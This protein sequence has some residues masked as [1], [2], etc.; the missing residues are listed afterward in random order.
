MGV[1]VDSGVGTGVGVLVG[2]ASIVACIRAFTVASML[3][4]GRSV[5]TVVG[6]SIRIDGGAQLNRVKVY[7]LKSI[8]RARTEIPP[9]HDFSSRQ[10]SELYGKKI[11]KKTQ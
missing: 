10:I 6:S 3:G 7:R 4:V 1:G 5:G 2:N 9:I 11:V 8:Q